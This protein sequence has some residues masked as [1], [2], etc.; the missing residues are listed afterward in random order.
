MDH[1]RIIKKVTFARLLS[2]GSKNKTMGYKNI[3]SEQGC[4]LHN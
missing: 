4:Q 3:H 2:Y 1:T